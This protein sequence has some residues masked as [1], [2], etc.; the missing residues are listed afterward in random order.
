MRLVHREQADGL[1]FERIQKRDT[2][3]SF[4]RDVNETIFI[5]R[6]VLQSQVLLGRWKRTVDISGGNIAAGEAVHLVFHQRNQ[7]RDD[8]RDR[9]GHK[10]RA[11]H[12]RGQLKDERLARARR[13]DRQGVMMIQQTLNRIFLS[14]AEGGKAEVTVE[15]GG[16]TGG[17]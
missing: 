6:K 5:L 16:E 15:G 14:G 7:R 1:C 10:T 12:N 13:H 9:G 4:G 8:E 11:Q 17:H 2:P 3:Q